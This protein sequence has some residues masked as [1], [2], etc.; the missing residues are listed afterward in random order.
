MAA[1]RASDAS[2]SA[3]EKNVARVGWAFIASY[4]AA[5]L[6]TS[7][8][9]IAPLLVT[10]ALKI[11]SLVGTDRAASSLSLIAAAGSLVALVANPLFG[12]LS[13]RTTSRWGMRR[14][15]MLIGLAGG[16]VGILVVAL[17][18]AVWMVLIGW[19]LA[20]LFFNAMLAA[21][22][23]VLPDQVPVEQ[24]GT[25][26]GVLGVCLPIASVGGTYVVK[27][28]TGSELAMFMAPCAMGGF[29][30][31]LFAMF[32]DDRRLAPADKPPWSLRQLLSTYYVSPGRHPD[33]AWAFVSRFM[34]ILAY[35]FLVTY[36]AY[37]LL[38][39]LGSTEDE[40]PQQIF[41]GTLIQAVLVVVASVV[42]GRL[43]DRTGRRKLFVAT[44]AVAYGLALFII[45]VAGDFDAFLVGMAVGGL[46]FGLYMAVDL[47]LVADV[48][49]DADNAAKD[50]GVL[51]IAG[52]L[53][54]SLAPAIAPLILAVGAGSYQ[55]LY[56]VAGVCA[57]LGAAAILPVRKVR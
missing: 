42:G 4:A 24:R 5:Y 54:F 48:L 23:A 29:F 20:Q 36:Q 1:Q 28:F 40:V 56:A 9:F 22:V 21:M 34:F 12:R 25:V 53:P 51:N 19:C 11:N 33:F 38:D 32:L 26:A 6:A 52:A 55:V 3:R 41:L 50:L 44:A 27:V 30:I 8:V 7:L 10:L 31:V 45:A 18:S 2:P 37:Y 39:H 46:G 43:S 47:A 17:A 49:P 15:W 35:A 57:L 14:P 16:S 13:D